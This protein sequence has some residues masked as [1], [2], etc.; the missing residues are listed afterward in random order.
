MGFKCGIIGLPNV[1]KSTL[2]NALTHAG[3]AMENYPFCTINPHIGV[4]NVPDKRLDLL[5]QIYKPDKIIPTTLQFVDIAGLVRGASQGEGL[6]NQFLSHIQAVD[7]IIH[8]VRCFENPNVAH[9]DEK[10]D[11]QRD[12]EI[13]ETEILL[14]DL[15]IV[16][17]RREKLIA[18]AKSGDEQTQKQLKI[19]DDIRSL[20]IKGQ[21]AKQY[22]SHPEEEY[23]IRDLAL[24][25]SKP[26]IILGNISEDEAISGNKSAITEAF[27]K[28]ALQTGNL[29]LTVSANLELELSELPPD[30]RKLLMNEWKITEPGLDRLI[31]A[32]YELLRLITFFTM[33]SKIVQAWTIPVNTPAVKAAAEIHTSFEDRFIKA[34]VRHWKDIESLRS[35]NLLR[36]QGLVHI[37]GK[38]YLVHDGDVITFKLAAG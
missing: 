11:P 13:V 8:V 4:V 18:R 26:V 9:I 5:A 30:D 25:S 31:R 24:L 37:E 12:I 16:E 36:E 10:L 35:E 32:G 22:H 33:E 19:L 23:F 6:G 2:F 14:K 20:L 15:E 17:N 38:S 3:V 29:F 7:A 34:E 27:E 21:S 1:G 28:F